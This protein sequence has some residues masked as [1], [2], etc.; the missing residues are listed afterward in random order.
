MQ[1][2]STRASTKTE[3][4]PAEPAPPIGC[5]PLLPVPVTISKWRT[6]DPPFID[7]LSRILAGVKKGWLG[8]NILLWQWRLILKSQVELDTFCPAVSL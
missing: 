5:R 2:V 3:Q 4:P 6:Q 8:M 1:K 7:R